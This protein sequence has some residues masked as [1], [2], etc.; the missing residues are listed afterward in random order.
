MKAESERLKKKFDELKEAK[1]YLVIEN[2]LL[3]LPADNSEA[4]MILTVQAKMEKTLKKLDDFTRTTAA[5]NR[6]LLDALSRKVEEE[7]RARAMDR[8]K[9]SHHEII[10]GE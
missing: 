9:C 2:E 5:D 7:N 3:N 6:K 4:W 1:I 10:E 8:V